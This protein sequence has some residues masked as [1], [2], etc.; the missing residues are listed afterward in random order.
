LGGRLRIGIL[1]KSATLGKIQI[2]ARVER[3]NYLKLAN[4]AHHQMKE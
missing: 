4:E 2:K 3:E 1:F